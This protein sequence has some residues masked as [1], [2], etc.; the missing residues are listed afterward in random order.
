MFFAISKPFRSALVA[1]SETEQDSRGD[2]SPTATFLSDPTARARK[3]TFNRHRPVPGKDD[4]AAPGQTRSKY[5][6]A[7]QARHSQ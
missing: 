6:L 5:R 1:E 2:Q 3:P 7:R 4:N